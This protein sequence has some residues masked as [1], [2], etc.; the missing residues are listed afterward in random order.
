M[1]YEGRGESARA[2]NVHW[3]PPRQNHDGRVTCVVRKIYAISM[4]FQFRL[5]SVNRERLLLSAT[6]TP[7]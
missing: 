3:S 5:T 2:G 6:G 7:D 1:E 4:Q